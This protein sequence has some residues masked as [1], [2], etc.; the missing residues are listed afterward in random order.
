MSHDHSHHGHHDHHVMDAAPSPAVT[1]MMP[2]DHA[3]M[4]HSGHNM[5][6]GSHNL[7]ATTVNH[8][9]HHMMSMAVSFLFKIFNH[10]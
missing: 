9:L 8:A 6:H 10:F 4:D 1:T 7:T 2:S 5:D 3:E